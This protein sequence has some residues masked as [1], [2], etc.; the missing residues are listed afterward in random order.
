MRRTRRVTLQA[1][2]MAAVVFGATPVSAAGEE[3]VVTME[4]MEYAP[5]EVEARVGDTIRFVNDD[6]LEHNVF[7]PTVGFGLDLG[8]Q[9]P[10]AERTMTPGKA[11]FFDVECVFHPNMLTK[12]IVRDE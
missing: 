6:T 1:A 11:G 12:V 7:V 3:H 10:G 2:A 9:E 8:K 4:G 5:A